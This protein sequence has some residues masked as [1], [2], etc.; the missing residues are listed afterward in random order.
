MA[1]CV[2]VDDAGT[3]SPGPW[4]RSHSRSLL[5]IICRAAALTANSGFGSPSAT[6]IFGLHILQ[7]PR[8]DRPAP[9]LVMRCVRLWSGQ[10]GDNRRQAPPTSRT[11]RRLL[12]MSWAWSY[13]PARNVPLV[14]P[15]RRRCIFGRV[16]RLTLQPRAVLTSGDP[17]RH[18][19]RR[20]IA[21]EPLGPRAGDCV[22]GARLVPQ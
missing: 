15:A 5:L 12:C 20:R 11:A 9:D 22:A 19:A 10:T 2:I 7:N 17:L 14:T 1:V 8:F 13:A 6:T 16:L 3:I 4:T 18:V 21:T